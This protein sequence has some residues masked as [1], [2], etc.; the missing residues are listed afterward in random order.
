MTTSQEARR[1]FLVFFSN[2]KDDNELGGSQLIVASWFFSS[3]AEDDD[4]LEG[5]TSSH[6]ALHFFPQV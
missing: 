3:N 5:F 4:E 2:A 6:Q 1:H